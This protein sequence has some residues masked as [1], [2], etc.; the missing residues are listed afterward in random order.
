[1][2]NRTINIE[3]EA[4]FPPPPVAAS[5]LLVPITSWPEMFRETEMTRVEFDLF[6]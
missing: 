1:M 6:W 2:T 3:A 5:E 4:A